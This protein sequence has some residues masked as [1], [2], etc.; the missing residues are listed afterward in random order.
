MSDSFRDLYLTVVG[1][2]Q[3]SLLKPSAAVPR[4]VAEDQL[5]RLQRQF[6]RPD[7]INAAYD[8]LAAEHTVL[9]HGEP[10]SGRSSA[11][12]VLLRELP[13]G[14]GTYHELAPDQP[15]AGTAWLSADLIGEEDRMLLDLSA[16]DTAAWNAVHEELSG[17]RHELL[18]KG[19]FLVVVLPHR[20]EDRPFTDFVH[21]TIG[22]PNAW[23]AVARHL[24]LNGLEDTIWQDHRDVLRDHLDTLPP[25]REVARLSDLILTARA[26]DHEE[27]TFADW[28]EA[29]I[30]ALT[31]RD[32]QVADLLPTLEE[33][34]QRALL[35]TA[36]MLD[37]ARGEA[38][39]R[40]T[41]VLLEKVGSE[42]DARPLLERSGLSHRLS[43][44]HATMGTDAC[45]RFRELGFARATRH[46]FW[47]NL[48]DVRAPMGEWLG[49]VLKL[50][51]LTETDR[52]RLV[53]RFTGMCL[54]TGDTES[55]ASFVIDWTRDGASRTTEVQAA[56]HLLGTAIES[57]ELGG[58][59]RRLTREWS[60]N[61]PT[62]NLR[63]VLV[64]VCEKVMSIHHP[65]AALVRLHHLARN[66]P[67]P[68]MAREALLRVASQDS[69]LQR[70]LLWRLA[71]AQSS[72]HRADAD[73]FLAFSDLPDDFL[74]VS[75]TR[76]WLAVCWRMAFD[77]HT[78]ERWAPCARHW[79]ATADAVGDGD[80]SRAA[81]DILVD[82]SASRYPV[83]S[84]IY[85]D[86]RR[87]VSPALS[88]QLLR[89]INRAQT[90]HFSRQS[91]D[92]EVSPS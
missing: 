20:F 66:E 22:R 23:E 69:R 38:V 71:T 58:Y 42:Q 74:L 5:I 72:H 85:A 39:H 34:G 41:T 55:L 64:E 89:T 3:Q 56:A 91:P 63:E 31:D 32:K 26:F 67:Q 30:A 54:S 2:T 77:L 40:A 68:G 33:G 81:L 36:A 7:G 78:P 10:G 1:A 75:A 65:D 15:K 92:L 60:A 37:G 49:Q 48:P 35:L 19:A 61:R 9:L 83:L 24:R 86:A 16:T 84:R 70:R 21:R 62:R 82:A 53:V 29:A 28:C 76:Q 57:E 4:R 73:L 25:M 11:A 88:A 44:V 47:I 80:L 51:E 50:R 45:V 87:T 52:E 8:V 14:R 12:R 79:L 6:A 17:F 43:N 90:S 59:F 27:G 13:R 46:H 18:R